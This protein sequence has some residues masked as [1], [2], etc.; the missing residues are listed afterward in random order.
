M[1]K[2]DLMK[3]YLVRHGSLPD[4]F[5]GKFVGSINAPLSSRGEDECFYLAN[6]LLEEKFDRIY[7]SPMERTRRSAEIIFGE[8]AVE[9]PEIIYDDRLKELNFGEWENRTIEEIAAESPESAK[10]WHDKLATMSFPGGESISSKKQQ[11]AGFYRELLSAEPEQP[12]VVTHGGIIVQ[13]LC[14]VL[15]LRDEQAW[16]LLPPRGSL[17]RVDVER[18]SGLGRLIFLGEKDRRLR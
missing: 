4:E 18:G 9:T 2:P 11:I 17:T 8:R 15:G 6:L 3:L 12:A 7:A 1:S 14:L 16:R 5:A 10:I 13:F